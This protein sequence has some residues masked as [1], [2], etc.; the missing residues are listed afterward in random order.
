[1]ARVTLGHVLYD[2]VVSVLG[3]GG[4]EEGW[5]S[6]AGVRSS[7]TCWFIPVDKTHPLGKLF[8]RL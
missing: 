3:A 8:P 4:T 2:A 7:A 1:M 5:D 6:A